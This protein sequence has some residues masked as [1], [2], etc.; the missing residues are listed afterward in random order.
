MR[1]LIGGVYFGEHKT[2]EQNGE[3]VAVD[4]M[5]YA[6]HEIE[7]IGR[8]GFETARKRRKK[9]TCV[10][11]ANVLDTSRLWRAVMQRLAAEYPDV[12]YGEMF[13]DNAAMQNLQKPR[14]VRRHRHREYVRGHPLR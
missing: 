8:I 6:E 12:E 14:A 4:V 11:K 1:E 13:V 2:F 3:K 5:P 9:L 7:R 10:D